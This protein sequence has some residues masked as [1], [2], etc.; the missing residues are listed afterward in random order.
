MRISDWSS[1]VCSSDLKLS[2]LPSGIVRGTPSVIG[3]GVVLD[4]WALKAEVEKLRAQGVEITPDRLMIAENCAL[5]LPFHR[6]LDA[7]REDA[8]GAG[9]NG[10]TRRGIGPA[11][12]DQVGRRAIRPVDHAHL[13]ALD[14]PLDCLTAHHEALQS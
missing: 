8:S 9:K 7:L 1:D 6:D 14:A 12:E 5:I 4:P 10:T 13:D 3:N 11:Y 2:L